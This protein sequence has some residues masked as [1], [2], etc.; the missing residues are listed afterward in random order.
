MIKSQATHCTQRQLAYLAYWQNLGYQFS[1]DAVIPEDIRIA[2]DDWQL[3][4]RKV[5]AITGAALVI[6]YAILKVAA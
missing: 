1:R 5:L 2:P 3:P 6:V 4:T